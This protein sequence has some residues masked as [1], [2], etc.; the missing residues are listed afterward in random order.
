MADV[1]GRLGLFLLLFAKAL[2]HHLRFG[3]RRFR[4]GFGGVFL[5]FER[6]SERLL[7]QRFDLTEFRFQLLALGFEFRRFETDERLTS[8][9]VI[10]F[11]DEDFGDAAAD[12][13]SEAD[14]LNLDGAGKHEH[15]LWARSNGRSRTRRRRRARS[16]RSRAIK[17]ETFADPL[18]PGQTSL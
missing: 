6:T 13:R 5:F 3:F 18:N 7:L 9:D 16:R 15:G 10:A 1:E 2:L 4:G 8:G 12:L 17:G 11:D 14:F